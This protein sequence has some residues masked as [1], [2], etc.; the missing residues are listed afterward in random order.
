MSSWVID[1]RDFAATAAQPRPS[2]MPAC[3]K[4]RPLPAP[5]EATHGHV[6]L[7]ADP[8]TVAGSDA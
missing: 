3:G 4:W 5:L 6:A 2:R 8:N 7:H 1:L